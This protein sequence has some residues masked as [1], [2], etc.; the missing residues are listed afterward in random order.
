M[1]YGCWN[2]VHGPARFSLIFQPF[3]SIW[4][5]FYRPEIYMREKQAHLYRIEKENIEKEKEGE[6][7]STTS[8]IVLW[9]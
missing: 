8:P 1:F 6:K 2:D 4:R 9:H 5:S 3:G 7:P